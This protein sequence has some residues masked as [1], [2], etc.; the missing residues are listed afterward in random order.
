MNK[1]FAI[2]KK[3]KDTQKKN[4]TSFETVLSPNQ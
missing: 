1:Q 3:E 2:T 4:L